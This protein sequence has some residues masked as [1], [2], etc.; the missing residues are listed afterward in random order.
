MGWHSDNEKEIDH[1]KCIASLSLG[2]QRDF[3]IRH[4]NNIDKKII[5]LNDGDLLI[6]QP[7]FQKNWHHSIPKRKKVK[8]SRINLTFRKYK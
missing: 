3:S 1:E 8:K 6:M 2:I 4:I 5:S 7:E